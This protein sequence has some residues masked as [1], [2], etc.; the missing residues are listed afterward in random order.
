MS[1][2]QFQFSFFI[3]VVAVAIYIASALFYRQTPDLTHALIIA[4]SCSSTVG[5]VLAGVM[6]YA[7]TPEQLGVLRE[8][9]AGVI[10]GTLAMIWISVSATYKSLMHPRRSAL[11][12]L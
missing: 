4:T 3:G 5:A 8:H 7:A 9:K 1:E 2:A 10:T 6:T 12:L 11:K